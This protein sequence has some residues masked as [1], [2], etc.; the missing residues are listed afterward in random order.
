MTRTLSLLAH[1]HQHRR[2]INCLTSVQW[3]FS[4]LLNSYLLSDWL[5]NI[6]V[7]AILSIKHIFIVDVARSKI[8]IK[9]TRFVMNAFL[10]MSID[11]CL[12]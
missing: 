6:R 1:R 12:F 8:F 3:N 5:V 9:I 2:K 4:T 10:K 11:F 7:E